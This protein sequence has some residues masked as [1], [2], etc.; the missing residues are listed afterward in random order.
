MPHARLPQVF[1]LYSQ[2]CKN[3]IQV[4]SSTIYF[5]LDI[6]LGVEALLKVALAK[7][8]KYIKISLVGNY[9]Y[10]YIVV[11]VQKI[12]YLELMLASRVRNLAAGVADF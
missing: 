11:N 7:C 1:P 4:M 6:I 10:V 12:L 5:Y 3:L 9:F 8:K 2:F